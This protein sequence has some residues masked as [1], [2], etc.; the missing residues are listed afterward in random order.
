[1]LFLYIQKL[2]A[3]FFDQAKIT[4]ITQ[5]R[6]YVVCLKALFCVIYGLIYHF[7]R[8]ITFI[9]MPIYIQYNSIS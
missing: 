6:T 3:D 8:S 7:Y 2:G 4:L 5:Y 9:F 1:M